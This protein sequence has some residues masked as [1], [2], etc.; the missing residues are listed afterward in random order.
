M[1]ASGVCDYAAP[2]VGWTPHSATWLSAGATHLLTPLTPVPYALVRSGVPA[3]G[4][5]PAAV[6]PAAVRASV[7]PATPGGPAA[8]GGPAF[9][10]PAPALPTLASSPPSGGPPSDPLRQA[11][12][13]LLGPPSAV[14]DAFVA[15]LRALSTVLDGLP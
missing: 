12:V 13:Q 6:R 10:S 4:G 9:V 15:T 2:P 14:Y 11:L 1:F 8:V 5:R 7:S 3:V